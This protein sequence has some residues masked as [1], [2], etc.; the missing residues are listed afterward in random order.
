MSDK[1]QYY[2]SNDYDDGFY[3]KD[4][5]KRAVR[6]SS[7]KTPQ[8]E[9]KAKKS[10]FG[11]FI[12]SFLVIIA[13]MLILAGIYITL[14][15]SRINYTNEVPDHTLAEETGSLKSENN[16]ENIMIFGEDNH[17]ENEHGRADTMILL[18]IDKVH[19]QLKQTSFMRDIYL[20]IP[21]HEYNKLNAS[22]VYG[23][24][25]LTVETIEYNFGI[26]IDNYIIVDFNSFTDIVNSLGGIDLELS[27]EEIEYI[28]MQSYR[29]HQTQSEQ[30]LDPDSFSYYYNEKEEQVAKV[31]LN[32]RQALWYARDRDS[33]GVDFD[34][35]QRQRIVVNTVFDKFR[36][37]DPFSTMYAVY[38][39]SPY[40]TTNMSPSDLTLKGFELIRALDYERCE[41]R[42]PSTDNYYDVWN[43]SG[44][45][46]QIADED[47][48]KQRLYDFI[49]Q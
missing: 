34:R 1:I 4:A 2:D 36:S 35:T 37:S 12:R 16:I 18:T 17:K 3:V 25:K 28:N 20:Y 22:Y 42:L 43:D 33:I 38:N 27:R 24:A 14:V 21:G 13:I 15:L 8:P 7:T 48:Q 47:L 49:F 46:L 10:L 19:N 5:R 32:G 26:K 11:R 29:N 6:K 44:L 45:A 40:L 23:G 39:A 30:E 41:H 9:Q 31:H